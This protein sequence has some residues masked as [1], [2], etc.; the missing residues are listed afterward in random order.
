MA[1]LGSD[2]LF[3]KVILA[4]G[5]APA[6]PDAGYVKIYAKS[7]GLVYGK[8][9]AGTETMLSNDATAGDLAAHLADTA[10][11]HDASAISVA[12]A[13]GLLT[14]TEVEAALAELAALKT[15]AIEF[16]ID[17]GGSEIADGIAGWVQVPFACTITAVRLLADVSGSI[18][19]DLWAED[20]A[21]YPP[22][23]A[24]TITASAVPTISSATKAQDATLT[25]WTTSIAAGDVI[26]YNVDSCTTIERCLVVLEYRR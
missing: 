5:A 15:G 11:A 19:V 6:T 14:A 18:V 4:E 12:D 3:P 21:N 7:D 2:N 24:D 26:Y 13:G 16:L 10:D 1:T 23:D 8:D 20:Y 22:T 9:D 17:G 25:G